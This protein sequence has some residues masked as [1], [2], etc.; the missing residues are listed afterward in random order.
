MQPIAEGVSQEDR[1]S[2]LVTLSGNQDRHE[3]ATLESARVYAWAADG[4]NAGQHEFW[5][6]ISQAYDR[7]NGHFLWVPVFC[8]L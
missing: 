8:C 4:A 5:R 1:F 2:P 3:L 7:D 6:T